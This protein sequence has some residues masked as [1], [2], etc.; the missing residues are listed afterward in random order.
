MEHA[1][2]KFPHMLHELTLLHEH[3]IGI[4][5]IIFVDCKYTTKLLM[6]A[7]ELSNAPSVYHLGKCYKYGKIGCLQ[8]PA[9]SVHY[10][11]HP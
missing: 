5:N 11:M 10:F 3:S 2:A 7:N 6:Q 1:T 8:D 4:N 9:L